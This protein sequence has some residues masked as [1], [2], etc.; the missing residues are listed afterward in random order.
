MLFHIFQ[1]ILDL[2]NTCILNHIL[3]LPHCT[4]QHNTLYYLIK[5]KIIETLKTC[6]KDLDDIVL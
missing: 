2:S 5:L 1:I 4:F 6:N 3:T